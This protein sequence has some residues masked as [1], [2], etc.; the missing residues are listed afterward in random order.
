MRKP[1]ARHLIDSFA[2]RY[3]YDVDYMHH[4]LDHAPAAFFKFAKINAAAAHRRAAPKDAYYAV[5]I[6]SAASADCGPCTQ[7]CV[8]MAREA[9]VDPRQIEAVLSDD[10]G[11]MNDTTRLGYAMARALSDRPDEL[12]SA[13]DSVRSAWG[14]EAVIELALAFTLGGVFPRLKNALGMGEACRVVRLEDRPV[15]VMRHAV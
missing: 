1:I 2:K 8:N 3:D 11:A 5:K 15:E 4:M 6:L 10:L 12:A 14:E 7:L 13:R 9:G